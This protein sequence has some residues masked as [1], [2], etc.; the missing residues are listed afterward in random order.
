MTLN[1]KGFNNPIKGRNRQTGFKNQDPVSSTGKKHL[2]P[3]LTAVYR[4]HI[5]DSKI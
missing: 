2:R 4:R 3:N 1:V 5:L